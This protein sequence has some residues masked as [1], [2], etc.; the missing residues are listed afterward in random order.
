MS[1]RRKHD[2]I[3]KKKF[4]EAMVEYNKL[5]EEERVITNY[6]GECILLICQNLANRSNFR[7]YSIQWKQEMISDAVEN[8]IQNINSFDPDM[9]QKNPFWY[10][11]KVAF[12]AFRRRIKQEKKQQ[13]VLHKNM[14]SFYLQN[15][16]SEIDKNDVSDKIIEDFEESIRK[17]KEKKK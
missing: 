12:N 6:I 10:F 8:C 4:Y 7:G 17:Q 13:Y 11:S 5:P 9:P 2:Y 14:H 3:D 1:K 15:K 16:V